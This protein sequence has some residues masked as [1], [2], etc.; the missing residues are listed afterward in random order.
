MKYTLKDIIRDLNIEEDCYK[1]YITEWKPNLKKAANIINKDF[2][3]IAVF[4]SDLQR[5][6]DFL[7]EI[8]YKM[9]II[10]NINGIVLYKKIKK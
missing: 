9:D 6:E 7:E 10:H 8:G 3:L 5:E 1:E 2:E 4:E